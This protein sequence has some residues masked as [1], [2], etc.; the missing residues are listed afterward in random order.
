[1]EI[2]NA[3]SNLKGHEQFLGTRM[4]ADE[5]MLGN[6]HINHGYRIGY[7]TKRKAA[8]SVFEVHNETANIWSHFLGAILFVTITFYV[9][10]YM[11]VID[12]VLDFSKCI[13]NPK[14]CTV[15]SVVQPID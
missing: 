13:A 7:N 8:K 14:N 10:Q 2:K 6:E 9:T 3:R 12:P 15:E 4:D 5:W 11:A 1:M